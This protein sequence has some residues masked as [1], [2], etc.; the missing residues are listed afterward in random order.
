MKKLAALLLALL[1]PLCA[2]AEAIRFSISAESDESLLL[3]SA[4]P[5]LN[6]LQEE[7]VEQ[8]KMLVSLFA[9]V[10]NG[11]GLDL[12][13]QG[14]A[15]EMC[16]IL[17]GTEAVRVSL[18]QRGEELLLVSPML[19]GYALRAANPTV[20]Q[21][22]LANAVPTQS[23][24]V[25]AGDA[26]AG[27]TQCVTWTLP[28]NALTELFLP[29]DFAD[30]LTAA[31]DSLDVDLPDASAISYIL[32]MV[33]NDANEVVGIS[34]TMMRSESQLATLSIGLGTEQFTVVTGLGLNE[35]NHWCRLRCS[36]SQ[37]ENATYLSGQVEE[38]LSAKTE[39]FTSVSG[40]NAPLA[41]YPV[42]ATVT[43]TQESLIWSGKL[44]AEN[45]METLA[46][47]TGSITGA[48]V[49]AAV[50]L[51]GSASKSPLTIRFAVGN[52][53]NIAPVDE[54][55]KTCAL[56][57]DAATFGTLVKQFSAAVTARMLKLLPMDVIMQLTL[58]TP[59]Q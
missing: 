39:S 2:S 33:Q 28:G 34:V 40:R 24:G 43:T 10:M 49:S 50:S 6:L 15:S 25:F 19:K 3:S 53:E 41:V 16:L 54:T 12:T 1:M 48:N 26:Y 5:M 30:A 59:F 36:I 17:S 56:S 51:G 57:E 20:A 14:D 46:T 38:W 27:G 8:A 35:Q 23:T 31:L 4:E 55:L 7:Y 47:F 58:Y 22:A 42:R 9:R 32:R 13:V 11:F 45:G 29:E 18:H 44:F 21:S 37:E 52:A